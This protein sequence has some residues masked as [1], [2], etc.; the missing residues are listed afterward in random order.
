MLKLDGPVCACELSYTVCTRIRD[1]IEND[2][3]LFFNQPIACAV[4]ELGKAEEHLLQWYLAHTVVF[5]RVF[6]FGS[7][8]S[9][10]HLDKNREEDV[11]KEGKVWHLWSDTPKTQIKAAMF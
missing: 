9:A 11:W 5:N 2:T 1:E 6:V 7:L 10:K 8:Q 4:L 3:L